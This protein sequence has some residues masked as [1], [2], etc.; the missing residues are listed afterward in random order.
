MTH[1]LLQ[2]HPALLQW[3]CSAPSWD[4]LPWTLRTRLRWMAA[5]AGLNHRLSATQTQQSEPLGDPVFVLGPWR[6][7]STAMHELL[8]AATGLPTPQTWQCM[9]APAFALSA[10]PRDATAAARPMDGLPVGPYSPQEDEFALLSLGGDSLYRAFWQ[11]TRYAEL[12]PLLEAAH[13][14]RHSSWLPLWENFL[15]AV[16]RSQNRVGEPLLLKS[17]NHSLRWRALRQRFPNAR[18]AW[19]LRDARAV[20]HSNLKMWH[21]MAALHGLEPAPSGALETLVAAALGAVATALQEAMQGPQPPVLVQQARLRDNPRRVVAETCAAL[22][23]QCKLD[24]A[25]FDSALATVSRGRTEHYDDALL[26]PEAHAAV[27][28]LDAAQAQAWASASDH[29]SDHH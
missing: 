4:K 23:L 5:W 2:L 24:S 1:A 28:V 18:S 8:V 9:N 15:Q 11:P 21:Q 29:R 25:A 27:A 10:P 22:N 7:G 20:Y 13:W 26:T 6:S 3:L 17:P 16:L 12:L 19:M 14:E